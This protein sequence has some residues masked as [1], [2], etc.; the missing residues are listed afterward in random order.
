[1]HVVKRAWPTVDDLALAHR[2]LP[3]VAQV[4]LTLHSRVL[5]QHRHLLSDGSISGGRWQGTAL[6]VE[7]LLTLRVG[8][9]WL[10]LG[11]TDVLVAQEVILFRLALRG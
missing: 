8:W 1:M 5:F 2:C 11:L 7:S 10:V 9:S 3:P 6:L 4:Q